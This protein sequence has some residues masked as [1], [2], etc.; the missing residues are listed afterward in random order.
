MLDQIM[1]CIFLEIAAVIGFIDAAGVNRGSAVSL[2]VLKRETDRRAIPD[3]AQPLDGVL[4]AAFIIGG[5]VEIAD[6][7]GKNF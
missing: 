7:A 1:A 3:L 2:D 6:D 5:F 4:P